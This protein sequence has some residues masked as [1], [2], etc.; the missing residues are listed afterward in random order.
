[1]KTLAVI[2]HWN[3]TQ[4]TDQLY[5]ML[6]PYE[7]DDYDL[8][9][10]DN[11][12]DEGKV[13]K[14]ASISTGQ[15]VYFGG[16]LNLVMDMILEDSRY[17]SLMYLNNDLIVHGHSFIPTIRE[18]AF[19]YGFNVASP[20]IIQPEQTQNHWKQML[21]WG[22]S[23]PR[24]V[25]WI[26]LQCPLIS[27]KFIRHLK[28]QSKD[29]YCIDSSLIWGWGIDIWFGIEMEKIGMKTAV[30]DCVPVVHMGSAT[31]KAHLDHPVIGSYWH[32]AEMGQ[33]EF[34]R[35]TNLVGDYLRMRQWSENYVIS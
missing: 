29:G 17:D 21:C 8:V 13:S 33:A 22:Q 20:C 35:K 18:S 5:E 31:V 11:G 1:M 14:Y 28:E 24:D 27:K 3:T 4:Y 32:N 15:N 26:D 7:R 12:S 10:L 9:V 23:Q 19:K 25:K 6:K 30:L 2:L 34:F 16:A